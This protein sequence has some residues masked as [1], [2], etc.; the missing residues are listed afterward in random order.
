MMK[1]L[2]YFV[3]VM[4][5]VILSGCATVS[6]PYSREFSLVTTP[7]DS[8]EK[9]YEEIKKEDIPKEV[10][11][12][13]KLMEKRKLD[14]SVRIIKILFEYKVFG[15]KSEGEG[16]KPIKDMAKFL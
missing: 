8:P 11:K 14:G 6:T 12:A 5:G 7:K 16:K 1:Y 9:S 15:S 10:E 2:T 13:A 4:T 3:V